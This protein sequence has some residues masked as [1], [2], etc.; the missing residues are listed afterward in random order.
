[1]SVVKTIKITSESGVH[2]RPATV[3]VNK[4]GSYTAEITLEYKNKKV[5]MKSI[6]GIMS[7]GISKGAD[8]TI[9][10]DGPDQDEAL[11]GM[12]EVFKEEGLG[13]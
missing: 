8:L 7:L 9:I 12:Y 10:A 2:A 5:N 3:L 4:A 11:E 13:E 1:M 6:M